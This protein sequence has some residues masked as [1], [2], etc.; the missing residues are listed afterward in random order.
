MGVQ[1][2][3]QN[4]DYM[5][6]AIFYRYT[7]VHIYSL[8]S[9][10]VELPLFRKLALCY[11]ELEKYQEAN[12]FINESDKLSPNH[13]IVTYLRYLINL[14]LKNYTLNKLLIFINQ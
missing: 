6:L 11:I 1:L 12:D 7:D 2:L 10:Y 13:I 14:K 5:N 8:P 4:K 9:R 3:Y